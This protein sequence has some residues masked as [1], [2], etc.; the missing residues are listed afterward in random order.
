MPV[1]SM[2]EVE[3]IKK[4][5]WEVLNEG[6][7]PDYSKLKPTPVKEEPPVDEKLAKEA[8]AMAHEEAASKWPVSTRKKPGPK[9]KVK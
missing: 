8:W 2:D 5:G 7:S 6:N 4:F 9:P 3:R 1:Y